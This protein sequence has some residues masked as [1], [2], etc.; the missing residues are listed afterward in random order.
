MED[1]F[2][3]ESVAN[4]RRLEEERLREEAEEEEQQ[5]KRVIEQI[6]Q[7]GILDSEDNLSVA[8]EITDDITYQAQAQE[9]DTS[10]VE[11]TNNVLLNDGYTFDEV[12]NLSL[13]D[14][15]KIVEMTHKGSSSAVTK[16]VFDIEKGWHKVHN[17]FAEPEAGFDLDQEIE[18]DGFSE[19]DKEEFFSGINNRYDYE[20]TKRMLKR[21]RA[22]NEWYNSLDENAQSA[23]FWQE[24]GANL[25]TD[26]ILI[27]VGG[28]GFRALTAMSPAKVQEVVAT[29]SR[30]LNGI[31]TKT[32]R[33]GAEGALWGAGFTLLDYTSKYEFTAKDAAISFGTATVCGM[34]FG[35]LRDGTKV[36]KEACKK[37]YG[38]KV[39]TPNEA[40]A[41]TQTKM[42]TDKE[43]GK[44]N[45]IVNYFQEWI[46][47]HLPFT[48][49]APRVL[50]YSRDMSETAGKL[51]DIATATSDANINNVEN[52]SQMENGKIDSLFA[53]GISKLK[54]HE[55]EIQEA[56]GKDVLKLLDDIIYNGDLP[57][58]VPYAK[59]MNSL[60]HAFKDN[61]VRI[62]QEF[63]AEG[64]ELPFLRDDFVTPKGLDPKSNFEERLKLEQA[65]E[66]VTPMEYVPRSYDKQDI[67]EN[68][69]IIKSQFKE[70][71]I[72][73]YLHETLAQETERATEKKV[74]VDE[75]LKQ[76]IK[77]YHTKQDERLKNIDKLKSQ[78]IKQAY[79]ERDVAFKTLC[80]M[81]NDTVT[82]LKQSRDILIDNIAKQSK[83]A[84]GSF[85]RLRKSANK[86]VD[87][88]SKSEAEILDK[89]LKTLKNAYDDEIK[90]L[91]K[92]MKM[93]QSKAITPDERKA[94]TTYHEVKRCQIEDEFL[95]KLIDNA[96]RFDKDAKILNEIAPDLILIKASIRT[97]KNWWKG[98]N[99]VGENHKQFSKYVRGKQQTYEADIK[100][101]YEARDREL[102]ELR[103]EEYEFYKYENKTDKEI[104]AFKAS[105]EKRKKQIVDKYAGY[106]A[107]ADERF[108]KDMQ[109]VYSFG[110]EQGKLFEALVSKLQKT[111][112]TSLNKQ[113]Q[114]G[115]KFDNKTDKELEKIITKCDKSIQEINEW[116]S[117]AEEK[118]IRQTQENIRRAT[119]KAMLA[120]KVID[121]SIITNTKRRYEVF[122]KDKASAIA[123]QQYRDLTEHR[124]YEGKS[125]RTSEEAR[126]IRIVDEVLR[127]HMKISAIESLMLLQ[128][129][130]IGELAWLKTLNRVGVGSTE[131][132]IQQ[133]K[134]E[135]RNKVELDGG[136]YTD[137]KVAKKVNLLER[138]VN[139]LQAQIEGRLMGTP[140][141]MSNLFGCVSWLCGELLGATVLNSLSDFSV[142]IQ[143]YGLSDVI[144]AF[145]KEL[146]A[147]TEK[148]LKGISKEKLVPI[149]D[150]L[151]EAYDE[152]NKGFLLKSF[153]EL[154]QGNYSASRRYSNQFERS[155]QA[156]AE[157]IY[158]VSGLRT[159][160]EQKRAIMAN[161][162]FK[163]LREK[164][165]LAGVTSEELERMI[166]TEN[167]SDSVRMYML[168]ETRILL[169]RAKYEDVPMMM[170]EHPAL[171][172]FYTFQQ[173][174]MS[175]TNNF[176]FPF[177]KGE[178]GHNHTAETL[179]YM[180]CASAIA[181][182]LRQ[183]RKGKYDDL[184][185]EE[186]RKDF[187]KKVSFRTMDELTGVFS[188]GV[189]L[190]ETACKSGRPVGAVLERQSPLLSYTSQLTVDVIRGLSDLAVLASTGEAPKRMGKDIKNLFSDV[191]TNLW[192]K[193]IIVNNIW[194][195][196]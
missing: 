106:K 153:P 93:E 107:K 53:K 143:R 47:A 87:R 142:A 162:A 186:G 116:A 119:G 38:L 185:T 118:A 86:L 179:M 136:L 161:L 160:E 3:S 196:D 188:V 113:K 95:E 138:A 154:L 195:T 183:V 40:A 43:K 102:E 29:C 46:T 177:L 6:N 184:T 125:I 76:L 100:S 130:L 12:E 70:G 189:G 5:R 131:Q 127:P 41:E 35:A 182:Y 9:L 149:L 151:T 146:P 71:A 65:G 13:A 187:I 33:M 28:A 54:G 166:D 158:R 168:Q 101:L 132:L 51:S 20:F 172:I 193:D 178:Y 155:G 165:Y 44:S 50:H 78:K 58:T 194:R 152:G 192:Q 4:Y 103:K 25:I 37:I 137:D 110:D 94:I 67:E 91:D 19:K 23:L 111:G 123:E 120:K 75:N 45:K 14:R 64:K 48:R 98:L 144:H 190:L 59:E 129:R 57:E 63:L 11:K 39:K 164:P 89:D 84:I 115:V 92:Q 79:K 171:K 90:A 157:W 16:V 56:T 134:D 169:N 104:E 32:L 175:F 34:A 117:E 7:A 10:Q 81:A 140:R 141:C 99:F 112:E 73:H 191:T 174:T 96:E 85:E 30:L 148:S 49:S 52:W 133:I 36:V 126:T 124:L 27:T 72:S 108:L 26:G 55:K 82:L 31:P 139:V 147:V 74:K 17:W 83:Q 145:S 170:K 42:N 18:K 21:E 167:F 69:P 180:F 163:N 15:Y 24:I 109:Q 62:S 156:F 181:E 105:I 2:S 61:Y 1:I 121:D 114:L 60:V 122:E 150:M 8:L 97:R 159:F 66:L 176:V 22:L 173:W 77:K 128:K 80:L 135:V 68:A 88:L